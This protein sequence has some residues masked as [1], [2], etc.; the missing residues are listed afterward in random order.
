MTTPLTEHEA[1]SLWVAMQRK[2]L[3]RLRQY[4]A[5]GGDVNAR[6]PRGLRTLFMGACHS[7]KIDVIR[8][9]LR[10]GADVNA[11]DKEGCTPLLWA[12]LNEHCVVATLRLL[13]CNGADASPTTQ[14]GASAIYIAATCCHSLLIVPYLAPFATDEQLKSFLLKHYEKCHSSVYASVLRELRK[15]TN[16]SEDV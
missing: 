2:D 16:R 7:G 1:F 5:A 8:L 13:V 15:R 14:Q 9:F 12:C 11:K 6:E 3:R 4:L 10:K